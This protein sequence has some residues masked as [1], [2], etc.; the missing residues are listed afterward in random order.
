MEDTHTTSS[1]SSYG[2]KTTETQVNFILNLPI[3]SCPTQHGRL[4]V[5]ETFRIYIVNEL[6]EGG[7]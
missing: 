5:V 1:P 3:V 2:L 7:D 6:T 4:L